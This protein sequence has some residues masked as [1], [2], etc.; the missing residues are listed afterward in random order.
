MKLEMKNID[1]GKIVS[2]LENMNF[3]GL[4]VIV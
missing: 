1:L 4:R 2:F 3:K